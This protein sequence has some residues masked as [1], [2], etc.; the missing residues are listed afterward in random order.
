[1]LF[2]GIGQTKTLR[3]LKLFYIMMFQLLSVHPQ[4]TEISKQ[5]I[6]N[7]RPSHK[8]EIEITHYEFK[9]HYLHTD[10]LESCI[11]GN[12]LVMSKRC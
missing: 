5:H 1:M 2:L 10:L 3:K 6:T 9:I 11:K 8:N 7:Y 4:K 12:C